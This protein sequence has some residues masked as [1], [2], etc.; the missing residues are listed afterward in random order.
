M[1]EFR[2]RATCQSRPCRVF[3]VEAQGDLF[4][5]G[6]RTVA[7][8]AL[9]REDGPHIAVEPDDLIRA[10]GGGGEKESRDVDGR[11]RLT[12]HLIASKLY[13]IREGRVLEDRPAHTPC[14][15]IFSCM[16]DEAPFLTHP[17]AEVGLARELQVWEYYLLA[18]LSYE[19]K[20]LFLDTPGRDD[21]EPA[22]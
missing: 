8:K 3:R 4:R 20:P 2:L 1:D 13:P 17:E 18:L 15:Y 5:D 7:A 14:R 6:I 16:P 12:R 11:N 10:E 19:V 21:E 9:V 22:N